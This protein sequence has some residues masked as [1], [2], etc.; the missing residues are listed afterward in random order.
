MARLNTTAVVGSTTA[1]SWANYFGGTV[2][3]ANTVFTEGTGVALDVNQNAY[4]AGD[5]NSPDLHVLKPLPA[6]S[7]VNG[8]GNNGGYDAF[9]TQLGSALSLSI[10][11]VLSQGTNQNFYRRREP[12]DLHYL[13]DHQQRS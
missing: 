7:G 12:G 10:T 6:T 9:V 4:F 13:H 1:T 2:G 11:G 8:A 3:D 5:T